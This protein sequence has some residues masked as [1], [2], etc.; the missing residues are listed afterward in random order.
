MTALL[1]I[2]VQDANRT[3]IEWGKLVHWKIEKKLGEI[4]E[5]KREKLHGK[6]KYS[7]QIRTEEEVISQRD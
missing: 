2:I 5:E 3:C 6:K 7:A 4:V 1:V